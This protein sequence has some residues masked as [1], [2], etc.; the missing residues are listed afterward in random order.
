MRLVPHAPLWTPG[1]T[2]SFELHLTILVPSQ[3]L[4]Y[5]PG[6]LETVKLAWVQYLA[7]FFPIRWILDTALATMIRHGVVTS[8]LHDPLRPKQHAF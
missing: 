5:Y 3:Q 6:V 2:D 1:V 8:R 7:L 4:S